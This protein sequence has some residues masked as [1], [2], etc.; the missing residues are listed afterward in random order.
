MKVIALYLPQYHE[1]EENNIWWGKGYTEWT[2]L[3][4]GKK[5]IDGQYQP[6]EPLDD[7]YYDLSNIDV[8]KWQVKLAKEHG[9]YGFC[10]YH[11][12]FN[13]KCLLE[14]PIE[15]FLD[16]K[17]IR[18]PYYLC[19]ANER[20]TT[21][22]EGETNPRVLM[23]QNYSDKQD[24]DQHF[25]YYL[26]FFEDER[27]LKKDNRPIL[28]IYNP[29]AIPPKLL[30]YTMDRWNTLAK[31]NGF[32]GICFLYLCAES[33]CYMDPKLKDLFDYGV[34]YQPS[35]VEHLEDDVEKEIKR[36]KRNYITQ[37]IKS[38]VPILANSLE[39]KKKNRRTDQDE[40]VSGVKYVRNYDEDWESILNIQHENY[41]SYIPGAFTDWD[42]TPRRARNGKVILGAT[43]DK[44]EKYFERQV[45]RAKDIYKSDT[46]V[47][48]AWN[49]WSEGGYLEPDKKWGT[50][51]LDAIKR[52]LVRQNEFEVWDKGD[53]QVR[54]T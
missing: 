3:K 17:E 10:F 39:K 54:R 38:K 18:F 16:H 48:F 8:M 35:L 20:W 2:S 13:G 46:I 50:G 25:Y 47:I 27:Y 22:W 15:Q 53:G 4:R 52:V 1:I 12:W 30:R 33:M 29:I 32:D 7:N 5:Y 21:I 41:S 37:M 11:Y 28:S 44:F 51:Y 9:V 40:Q 36:Y 49:E 26:K 23:E 43:P 19:W 6:R 42:N 24:I 45:Q 31:E 34:E 14:K